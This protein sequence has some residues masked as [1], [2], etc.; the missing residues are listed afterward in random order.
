MSA[1]LISESTYKANKKHVC[2]LC[3]QHIQVGEKYIRQFCKDGHAYS[4]KMHLVCEDISKH[5]SSEYYYDN[6]GYDSNCFSYDV[7]ENFK[8]ITGFDRNGM[9]YQ[10][11][12]N[13]FKESWIKQRKEIEP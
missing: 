8:E 10:D 3:G 6:E 1:T 9:C 5:Y 4:F 7:L 12:V 13:I 11:S 2:D